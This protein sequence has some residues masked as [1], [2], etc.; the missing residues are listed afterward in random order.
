MASCTFLCHDSCTDAL[1]RASGHNGV[2]FKIHRDDPSYFEHEL[3]WLPENTSLDDALHLIRDPNTQ[4][5]VQKGR[6]GRIAIRFKPLMKFRPLRI[7][8]SIQDTSSFVDLR[9]QGSQQPQV[10]MD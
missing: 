9:S 2:F 6:T 8:N 10:C 1:L 3:L 4:G 7:H 5:L